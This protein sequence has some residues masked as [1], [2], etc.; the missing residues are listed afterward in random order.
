MFNGKILKGDD[1]LYI[2]FEGKTADYY[3]TLLSG[4]NLSTEFLSG[5][6]A[7][8]ENVVIRLSGSQSSDVLDSFNSYFTLTGHYTTINI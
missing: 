2:T 4:D 7:D 6:E 8:G 3:N 1:M 5:I